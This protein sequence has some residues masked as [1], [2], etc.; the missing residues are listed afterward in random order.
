[1]ARH[2]EQDGMGNRSEQQ[3]HDGD[4]YCLSGHQ[5]EGKPLTIVELLEV[6]QCADDAAAV[7]AW[8]PGAWR[9]RRATTR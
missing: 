4:A 9:L 1:M 6:S 3:Q 8:R 7:S 2:T 5:T